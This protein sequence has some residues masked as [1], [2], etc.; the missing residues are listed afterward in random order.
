M[1]K[2]RGEDPTKAGA[3]EDEGQRGQAAEEQPVGGSPPPSRG[4][5]NAADPGSLEQNRQLQHQGVTVGEEA[6]RPEKRWN[7]T[8]WSSKGFT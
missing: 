2:E 7:V 4:L 5:G 1:A 8:G 6:T 3:K